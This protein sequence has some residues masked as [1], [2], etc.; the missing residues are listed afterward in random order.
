MVV[1][2]LLSLSS[3]VRSIQAADVIMYNDALAAGWQ[4]WSWGTTRD[5]NRTDPVYSGSASIAVTYTAIWGG[6]YLHVNSAAYI[7]SIEYNTGLHSDFGSGDRLP[8]SGSPIGISFITVPGTQPLV[9]M[10]FGYASES[11]PGSYPIPPVEGG[12]G[13]TAT[14]MRWCW[15]VIT[16]F[17]M[18]RSTLYGR[19]YSQRPY[20][21]GSP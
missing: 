1:V 12:P 18:R 20:L 19:G 13:A 8:G 15:I 7:N 5:F 6:L 16:A 17:C 4:D 2:V 3:P 9:D 11:D 14:G 21:A 10:T